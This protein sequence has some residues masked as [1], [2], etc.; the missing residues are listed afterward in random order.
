LPLPLGLPL[1]LPVP[2]LLL[3]L[4]L[5]LL[6]HGIGQDGCRQGGLQLLHD[7]R[8]AQQVWQ[9]VCH[10]L[11]LLSSC[12]G[13]GQQVRASHDV[14]RRSSRELFVPFAGEGLVAR[15]HRDGLGRKRAAKRDLGAA[16]LLPL[17]LS[18]LCLLLSWLCLACL[19]GMLW[20]RAARG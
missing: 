5:L 3:L 2:Q 10:G 4:L 8:L 16:W 15:R 14:R 12:G 7:V 20:V 13:C 9:Q 6:L 17:L 1:L 19:P 18:L 11:G